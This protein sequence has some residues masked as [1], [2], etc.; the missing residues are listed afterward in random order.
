M[1]TCSAGSD[2]PLKWLENQRRAAW[3]ILGVSLLHALYNFFLPFYPDEAYYWLWSRH[4]DFSY[5]DHPPMVAYLIRLFSHGG[6]TSF[7][8]A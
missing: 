1:P 8:S 2:Y 4:L 7:S 5:Y 3:F 6:E